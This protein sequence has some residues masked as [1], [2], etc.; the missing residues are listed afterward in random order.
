MELDDGEPDRF[1]A[2]L[3]GGGPA[4]ARR[5][6]PGGGIGAAPDSLL[7]AEN[8]ATV[9]AAARKAA[10]ADARVTDFDIRPD[11]VGLQLVTGGRELTLDYGYDAQLTSRGLRARTGVDSGS[12]GWDSIDPE[13]P[14][15]MARAAGRLL[16][17]KLA[18]VQYVLLDL[19]PIPGQKV[20]MYFPNGHEPLYGVADLNGRKFSWPGRERLAVLTVAPGRAVALVLR[21]SAAASWS[22]TSWGHRPTCRD[23][24]AASA[25]TGRR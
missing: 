6:E 7:R 19:T 22:L 8:L 5:A 24:R 17:E 13:A 3:D 4:A 20:S 10:P 23:A 12:I 16:D 11:R 18:D 9:I 1:I 2:N 14:E 15:R 25:T 21:C